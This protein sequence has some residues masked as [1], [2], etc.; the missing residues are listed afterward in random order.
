LKDELKAVQIALDK[1]KKKQLKASEDQ[2][3]T[4]TEED[5]MEYSKLWVH[6]LSKL[7][8]GGGAFDDRTRLRSPRCSP[9]ATNAEK[10]KAWQKQ[11][12]KEKNKKN[13]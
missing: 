2:G 1:L 13:F 5:I 10:H 9:P 7:W 4:L 8:R 11:F 6:S 3:F 12:Q